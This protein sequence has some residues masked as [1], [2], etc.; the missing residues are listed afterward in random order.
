MY[1][2]LEL[3]DILLLLSS[4]R[5]R[6]GSLLSN[7][8]IDAILAIPLIYIEYGLLYY[9]TSVR[10]HTGMKDAYLLLYCFTLLIA[11]LMR[12]VFVSYLICKWLSIS[13]LACK[14]LSETY[15]Y[16]LCI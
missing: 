2:M 11:N 3:K 10:L 9:P 1:F 7:A 14:W 6:V 5:V 4:S 16:I 13:C 8:R 12:E 15:G